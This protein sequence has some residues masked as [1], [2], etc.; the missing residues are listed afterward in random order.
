MRSIKPWLY[1]V[2]VMACIGSATAKT[3]SDDKVSFFDPDDGMLD[4]SA[5][6]A[7]ASGFLPVPILITEPAVGYGA[8]AALLFFH[9]SIKDRAGKMEQAEAEGKTA[10]LAPPSISGAAGFATEN[11]TWGG[12]AFHM[13]IWKDDTIRY[14]GALFYADVNLDFYGRADGPTAGRAIGY[15]VAA[16]MLYQRMLFRVS[17]SDFFV[18]ADYIFANTDMTLDLPVEGFPMLNN[19]INEAAVGIISQH[20]TRDNTFTPNSG[21]LSELKYQRYDRAVGGDRDYNKTQAK[22]YQWFPVHPKVIL[23]LRGDANFSSGDVPFYMLPFIDLRGIPA[24]RY[25]G[26]HTFVAETELR[27]DFVERWSAVGF[28][29]SGWVAQYE[30]NDFK[31]SDAYVAGGVGVR[32]LIAKVFNMRVGADIAQGPEDTAFYLTMGS[33]W[34]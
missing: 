18:G 29:G 25:Q 2:L 31:D 20:D 21:N 34:R 14:V 11:G 7:T 16:T 13:G 24:L 12:G 1:G 30:F 15:N 23:G 17:E 32:Y 4:M 28:I 5:F 27:W 3:E 9:D 19:Q 22:T 26:A 8:G 33:R 10:R 6:L